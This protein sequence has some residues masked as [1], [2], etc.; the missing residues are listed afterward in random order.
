MS[1]SDGGG[2]TT[3]PYHERLMNPALFP[4]DRT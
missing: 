3:V 1:D 2:S 4:D